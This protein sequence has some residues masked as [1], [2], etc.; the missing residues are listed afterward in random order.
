MVVE[1]MD[2]TI[3]TCKCGP[4][5]VHGTWYMRDTCYPRHIDISVD[6]DIII[7]PDGRRFD[8]SME[9]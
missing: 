5:L 3:S 1:K 8:Q 6:N 9:E 7:N 4:W 2:R